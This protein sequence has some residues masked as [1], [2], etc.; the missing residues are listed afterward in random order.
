M[1]VFVCVCVRVCVCVCVCTY[2]F[3]GTSID[4]NLWCGQLHVLVLQ[5]R[6][7]QVYALIERRDLE[8]AQNTKCEMQIYVTPGVKVDLRIVRLSNLKM[9]KLKAQK[10]SE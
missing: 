5:T 1:C 7:T 4:R 6:T 10:K 3:P 9:L 8:A 2:E